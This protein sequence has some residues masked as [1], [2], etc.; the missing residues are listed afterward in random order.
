MRLL[1]GPGRVLLER[2]PAAG[3]DFGDAVRSKAETWIGRLGIEGRLVAIF[4]GIGLEDRLLDMRREQLQ[5][6]AVVVER[7]P[8]D[9]HGEA[10]VIL[11]VE[12]QDPLVAFG[13]GD[14]GQGMPPD[15]EG[16]GNVLGRH[17]HTVAPAQIAQLEI[18][19]HALLAVGQIDDARLAVLHGRQFGTGQADQLPVRVVGGEGP[20]GHVG[21]QRLGQHRTDDRVPGSRHLRH[22]HDQFI[23]GVG[24]G[25]GEGGEGQKAGKETAD[26]LRRTVA[27]G[28]LSVPVQRAN[29]A[30]QFSGPVSDGT[31]ADGR[32]GWPTIAR[33]LRERPGFRS[34]PLR[35]N[36][37]A[38]L[39]LPAH[40][41]RSPARAT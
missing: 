34:G 35:R 33:V 23:L 3:D 1:A 2:D 5:P 18:D 8:V 13:R 12:L 28:F 6:R 29:S 32:H 24:G 16:E 27:K 21:D 17:R 39:P 22:G 19:L 9:R 14:A 38:S 10:P 4:G 30:A 41:T 20:R 40:P 37:C 15:L 7:H 36:T 31:S 25:N 26:H 11:D